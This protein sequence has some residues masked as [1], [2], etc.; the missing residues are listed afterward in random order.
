VSD[1]SIRVAATAEGLFFG[2]PGSQTDIYSERS[3]SASQC[4]RFTDKQPERQQVEYQ[5]RRDLLRELHIE[6]IEDLNEKVVETWGYLSQ[7]WFRLKEVGENGRV[8][9]RLESGFGKVERIGVR[10]KVVQNNVRLLFD[11]GKGVMK[12]I[13]A[14]LDETDPVEVAKALVTYAEEDCRR[15]GESF[16]HEVEVKRKR[17]VGVSRGSRT[18][19]QEEQRGEHQPGKRL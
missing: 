9:R 1:P 3:V 10:E 6:S 4:G 5:C 2:Q 7:K 18:H 14:S 12:G 11:I 19:G 17:F 13:G 8:W 15:R 16:G